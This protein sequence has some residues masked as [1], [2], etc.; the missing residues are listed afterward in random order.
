MYKVTEDDFKPLYE[1]KDALDKTGITTV[2]RDLISKDTGNVFRAFYMMDQFFAMAKKGNRGSYLIA[3][4]I[5]RH[6][7][8]TCNGPMVLKLLSKYKDELILDHELEM[9]ARIDIGELDEAKKIPYMVIAEY[10]LRF[11]A[12]VTE[13]ALIFAGLSGHS[14]IKNTVMKNPDQLIEGFTPLAIAAKNSDVS[15]ALELL[16]N[17]AD[18]NKKSTDGTVALHI[19]CK[20]GDDAIVE[21]LIENQASVNVQCNRGRSPLHWAALNG[22]KKIVNLLIAH[23]AIVDIADRAGHTPLCDAALKNNMEICETLLSHGADVHYEGYNLD[24]KVKAIV[25]PFIIAILEDHLLLVK[26]FI[27]KNLHLTKNN[28]AQLLDRA[29]RNKKINMVEL[30]IKGGSVFGE[31]SIKGIDVNQ[32]LGE[33]FPIIIATIFSDI[34]IVDLL[35]KAGANPYVSVQTLTPFSYAIHKGDE[36]IIQLLIQVNK[37]E[38]LFFASAHGYTTIVDKILNENIDINIKQNN[39]SLLDVAVKNSAVD[40][41]KHLLAKGI[42]IDMNE[43]IIK[44][45][46]KEEILDYILAQ[47]G[48]THFEKRLAAGK[49]LLFDACE[50]GQVAVVGYL[51]KK[52]SKES[53]DKVCTKQKLTPLYIASQNG[54]ADIVELLLKANARP[55]LKVS[56]DVEEMAVHIA[57]QNGHFEIVMMLLS[58]MKTIGHLNRALQI[59]CRKGENVLAKLLIECGA[60]INSTSDNGFTPLH[61]AAIHGHVHTVKTLLSNGAQIDGLTEQLGKNALHLACE[62]NQLEIV[63]FL[64]DNGLDVNI[65]T[66]DYGITPLYL[67]CKNGNITLA[68]YL[69]ENNAHPEKKNVED[70]L[71]PMDIASQM[72]HD[73]I[74]RLLADCG[75]QRIEKKSSVNSVN[76]VAYFDSLNYQANTKKKKPKKQKENETQESSDPIPMNS[77]KNES[78]ESITPFIWGGGKLLSMNADVKIVRSPGLSEKEAPTVFFYCPPSVRDT[79]NPSDFFKESGLLEHPVIDEK[80]G[81]KSLTEID[82]DLFELKRH[83]TEP[84]LYCLKVSSENLVDGKRA[85]LYAAFMFAAGQHTLGDTKS[86]VAMMKNKGNYLKEIFKD[87]KAI[88]PKAIAKPSL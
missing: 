42:S 16:E 35:L 8:K 4:Y 82:E 61:I 64:V 24:E 75:V 40:M 67:A 46:N 88:G 80:N 74:V 44:F 28:G 32:R 45:P 13:N 15:L 73:E 10:L 58:A 27:K 77:S 50:K 48:I 52:S 53:I 83:H 18:V 69:I 5:F 17:H 65:A 47:R 57:F 11:G 41:V 68:K 34:E 63:K 56:N 26:N 55:Y 72:N 62:R 86:M 36:D 78:E 49:T 23:G 81:L 85:T 12:K 2:I 43:L 51:L 70:G 66:V 7:C 54:Y 22:K 14:V 19:A 59:C 37:I 20:E 31:P 33:F 87:L 21:L 6:F 38:S 76:T 71:S 9:F 3:V 25:S 39:E 84:R 60:E 1:V 79:I 30:L 29:I